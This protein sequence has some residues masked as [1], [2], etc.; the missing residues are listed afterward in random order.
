MVVVMVLLVGQGGGI[1][2]PTTRLLETAM[3][4]VSGHYNIE[5]EI[6]HQSKLFIAVSVLS[7]RSFVAWNVA[8]AK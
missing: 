8:S 6:I 4:Q 3:S 2:I 5:Y 7:I 1:C